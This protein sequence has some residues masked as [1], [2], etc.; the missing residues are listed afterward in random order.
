MKLKTFIEITVRHEILDR[1]STDE[2]CQAA[3]D[4]I[5]NAL[6][7]RNHEGINTELEIIDVE[8]ILR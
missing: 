4:E 6:P 3:L 5:I 2:Q 1:D 8:S 7:K